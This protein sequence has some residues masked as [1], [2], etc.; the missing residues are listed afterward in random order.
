M[1][2]YA[3]RE[4]RLT[5][6]MSLSRYSCCQYEAIAVNGTGNAQWSAEEPGHHECQATP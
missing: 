1:R 3:R 2:K 4:L 5:E 6:A